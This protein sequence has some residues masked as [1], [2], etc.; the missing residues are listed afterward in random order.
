M[1]PNKLLER[2]PKPSSG[3]L[4][5]LQRRRSAKLTLP[6]FRASSIKQMLL[7]L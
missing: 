2:L 7:K 3:L 6:S 1:K 4:K 5:K